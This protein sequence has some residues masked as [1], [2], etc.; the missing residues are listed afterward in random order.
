MWVLANCISLQVIQHA[1]LPACPYTTC[2]YDSLDRDNQ[3][4]RKKV[5]ELIKLGEKRSKAGALTGRHSPAA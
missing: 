2:R 4:L 3:G 5:A 1:R